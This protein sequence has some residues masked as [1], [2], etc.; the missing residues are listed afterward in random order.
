MVDKS[1]EQELAEERAR[2]AISRQYL[3]GG[4]DPSLTP[5]R[6]EQLDK[7]RIPG[8]FG[9][10]PT[11][12]TDLLSGPGEGL[13]HSGSPNAELSSTAVPLRTY[14][15]SAVAFAAVVGFILGAIWKT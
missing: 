7:N 4:D 2:L 14:P 10:E 9:E 3:A 5:E 6:Q 8:Q 15:S 12:N 1:P 13:H 11:P